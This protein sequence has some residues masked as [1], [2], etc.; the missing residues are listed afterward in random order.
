MCLDLYGFSMQAVI[1]VSENKTC[2][3]LDISSSVWVFRS[4]KIS[5]LLFVLSV[6]VSSQS[7]P[8]HKHLKIN[9]W[10]CSAL[11][12]FQDRAGT[13]TQVLMM[14]GRRIWTKQTVTM[15]TAMSRMMMMMTGTT[16]QLMALGPVQV[17]ALVWSLI[18][19]VYSK[20]NM[21]TD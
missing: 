5:Q 1:L 14:I 6:M 20:I 15:P 3:Y 10:H 18:P 7:Q 4:L 2:F 11:L 19:F 16:P 21:H 8:R 12:S 13:H 17:A 9:H